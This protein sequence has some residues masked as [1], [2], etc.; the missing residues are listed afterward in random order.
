MKQS[1]SPMLQENQHPGLAS[2]PPY[3]GL[4]QLQQKSRR[5]GTFHG[6]FDIPGPPHLSSVTKSWSSQ[7]AKIEVE[8]MKRRNSGREWRLE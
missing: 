5:T 1:T 7:T 4:F 3:A 8:A 2:P 6:G